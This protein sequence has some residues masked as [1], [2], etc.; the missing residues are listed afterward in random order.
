[1][2]TPTDGFTLI[3]VVIT[4]FFVILMLVFFQ[5][6]AGSLRLAIIQ[7]HKEIAMRVVTKKIS[8]VRASG[9]A[10]ATT[11]SAFSDPLLASLQNASASTTISSY[12]A[13]IR[14]IIVGVTWT[15]LGSTTRYLS[16]STLLVDSG[17]L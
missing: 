13:N 6:A 1:M 11:S 17:G 2:H 7:Q 10:N 5:V 3:E 12:N 8:T 9:Y 14:Q 15:E 16:A 4:I